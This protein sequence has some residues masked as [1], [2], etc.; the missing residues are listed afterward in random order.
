[1]HLWRRRVLAWSRRR[2]H[3]YFPAQAR[4]ILGQAC[5]ALS[6]NGTVRGEMVS[7]N[8]ETP[9]GFIARGNVRR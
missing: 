3:V 2:Y 8:Q 4:Q 6:S 1:M 7:N 5:P 9:N